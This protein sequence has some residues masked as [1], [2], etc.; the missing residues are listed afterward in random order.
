MPHPLLFIF[1]DIMPPVGKSME[2]PFQIKNVLK[3]FDFVHICFM[4][5][6]YLE[7]CRSFLIIFHLLP[8]MNL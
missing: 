1:K 7:F 8:E 3:K 5:L 2:F 6:L 4:G